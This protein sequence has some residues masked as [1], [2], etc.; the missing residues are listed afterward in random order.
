[1][2]L[3]FNPNM[4]SPFMQQVG[5]ELAK[6][7]ANMIAEDHYDRA[8]GIVVE[9]NTIGADTY[10]LLSFMTDDMYM[11]FP[12]IQQDFIAHCGDKLR[13]LNAIA[14]YDESYIGVNRPERVLYGHVLRLIYNGAKSGD[15]YC[16]ELLK[17]LYK[18]YHKKEYNQLKKFHKVSTADI[19]CITQTEQGLNEDLAFARILCIAPFFGIELH[20][21]CAIWFKLY[22][23]KRDG[24]LKLIDMSIDSVDIDEQVIS[25]AA[26]TVDNWLQETE[27]NPSSIDTFKE[28]SLFIN[29]I[30][31]MQGF[32]DDYDKKCLNDFKGGRVHL[33][34]TL[35]TLK[36]INPDKNY[37]YE[38]V[39]IYTHIRDL[40]LALS[41]TAWDFDYGVG[42]LLGEEIDEEDLALSRYKPVQ[43]NNIKT[44]P[45]AE[46]ATINSANITAGDVKQE[47][48]LEEISNLRAKIN[49]LEQE[50]SYLRKE[51]KSI[52][53][54]NTSLS[55]LIHQYENERGELIKLREYAYESTH[56]EDVGKD[57]SF[58][59]IKKV[60]ER[61][62][63]L[64]IGGHPNWISK[65]KELFSNWKYVNTERF[66]TIDPSITSGCD[67][68]FFFTDFISHS[69]YNK[70]TSYMN[71]N[72]ISYGY[73]SGVNI[74]AT[75][76]Q[77]YD[78]IELK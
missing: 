25:D 30:F 74:E 21:D 34:M 13:E 22:E 11:D 70:F 52:R 18:S 10:F 54:E 68:V 49:K 16:V 62:K 61:K 8:N 41:D 75:I 23:K 51:F 39:Q 14:W 43:E 1:M 44:K 33:I 27:R 3:P 56:K 65:L 7:M 36:T 19:S 64:I 77:I 5:V 73:L 15:G 29:S 26:L 72:D 59:E 17:S 50:N 35:A 76:K 9:P 69:E 32:C 78:A 42:Y 46:R 58:D 31:R 2:K 47:D 38:D 60:I 67:K 66:S 55:G 48:Y 53:N 24:F 63:V 45:K 20:E 57:I 12:I 71:R 4:N 37:T 6:Q 28:T 40:V